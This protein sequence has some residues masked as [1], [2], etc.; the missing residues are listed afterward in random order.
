MAAGLS[1]PILPYL[2]PEIEERFW[3]KVTRAGPDDCWPWLASLNHHGYGRFKIASYTSRHAN[4][5]AW[6]I[7]HRVE[8][9]PELVIRHSCDNPRCCNPA[10]L[11]LGTHADNA[12]DKMQRGRWRGGDMAGTRNPR[13]LLTMDQLAEIVRLLPTMPNTYIARRF[14][15]GHSIISKIRTG[16]AWQREAAQFGWAPAQAYLE[17]I[18]A[19]RSP[20]ANANPAASRSA[21]D[22]TS[23]TAAG[24]GHWAPRHPPARC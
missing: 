16:N 12:A 20:H 10:H 14:P 5:V 15:V 17:R 7:A 1:K 24:T 4:R 21:A 8:P 22:R 9:A 18:T 19:P 2:S 6:V 3:E 11:L 13:C 23:S